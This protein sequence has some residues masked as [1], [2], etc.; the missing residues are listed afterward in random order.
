MIVLV[1]I[2]IIAAWAVPNY[3]EYVREA[4]RTDAMNALQVVAQRLEQF[5]RQCPGVGYSTNLGGQWPSAAGGCT[6]GGVGLGLD[7]V[8]ANT[9]MVSADRHYEITV[10]PDTIAGGC[11]GTMPPPIPPAVALPIMCG[12]TII[13]NPGGSPLP[14]SGVRA[15]G[16]LN[17]NGA[18][19]LD[20]TGRREWDRQNNGTFLTQAGTQSGWSKRQ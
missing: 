11:V 7:P 5:R 8:A 14:Q 1:I 3:T 4:R 20:S 15:S 10:V 2:G 12:Y 9:T 13:A 17:S 19:R 16:K 18:L 6:A